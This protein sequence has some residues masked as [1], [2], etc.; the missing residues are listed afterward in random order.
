MNAEVKEKLEEL[1]AK[2]EPIIGGGMSG[3]FRVRYF[4]KYINIIANEVIKELPENNERIQFWNDVKDEA[5]K[6]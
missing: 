4:K 6:L 5:E 3:F 1:C 2:I